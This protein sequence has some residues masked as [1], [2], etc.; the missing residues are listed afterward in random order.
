MTMIFIDHPL[1]RRLEMAQAERGAQYVYAQQRLEPDGDSGVLSVAGGRVLSA[2]AGLPVDR[3]TGLGMNGPVTL[4]ELA[5]VETFY[6]DHG[7]PSRI[8]LCPLADPT[9]LDLLQQAEYRIDTFY[10]VLF[11]PLPIEGVAA[12]L[13]AELQVSLAKPKE[14]DLWIKTTA[15]GFT[16]ME[17]PPEAD[18]RILTPNFTS[19]GGQCFFVWVDGQ[20]A[21]GGGMYVHNGVAE[22]GGASTLMAYRNRGVQTTLLKHRLQAAATA[23]CDLAMVMS[24]PGSGS[25][26]N[27]ERVG[28]RVAYTKVVMRR[29][30]ALL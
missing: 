22:F 25:H 30:L 21:G 15:Q 5:E 1:A 19:E 2:G 16:E 6:R 26:R 28:F 3:A 27:A 8:D 14:A 11:C 9:L 18:L 13:T 20:P 12:G 23:G 24:A 10:S 4:D 17:V 7:L 29:A